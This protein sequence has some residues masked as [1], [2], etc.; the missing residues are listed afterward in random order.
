[1]TKKLSAPPALPRV[2]KGLATIC[3]RPS[4]LD[5]NVIVLL[6]LPPKAASMLDV[7]P[8]E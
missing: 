1:M 3:D 4:D 2:I 6:N 7:G 8:V 5:R